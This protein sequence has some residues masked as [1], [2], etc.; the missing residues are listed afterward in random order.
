MHYDPVSTSSPDGEWPREMQISVDYPSNLLTLLFI[1]QSWRLK[2]ATYIPEL[3][4][5]PHP[6]SSAAP[7]RVSPEEWAQR[8]D[9]AWI[10]AWRWYGIERQRELFGV[11]T[12]ETFRELVNK[13]N[14]LNPVMS[15]QW[16]IEYGDEGLDREAFYAWT[17]PLRKEEQ[18]TEFE[19][20]PERVS[21]PALRAAWEQGL[22]SIIVLPFNVKWARRIDSRHLAVS[23]STRNDP[24]AYAA[25]LTQS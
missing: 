16:A 3:S 18:E 8:W 22:D 12:P 13:G 11:V 21:L 1:R 9:Q 20:E 24:H 4:L 19:T 5:A 10:Q 23:T 2:T 17:A 7:M 25:A 14:P 6:G 15:P